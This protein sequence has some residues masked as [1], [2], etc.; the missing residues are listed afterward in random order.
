[1]CAE[2]WTHAD[3][4]IGHFNIGKGHRANLNLASDSRHFVVIEAKMSSR[5]SPGVRNAPFFNQAARNIACIAEVLKRADRQASGFDALGFHVVA[6]AS[7][8]QEGRF[9]KYLVKGHVREIVAKRVAQYG[10]KKDTWFSE[11]FLPVLERLEINEISWEGLIEY[12]ESRNSDVGPL[13]EFYRRCLK[14]NGVK[15]G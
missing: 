4:V 10:G 13:R 5:L 9:A 1:M 12:L 11:W 2:T 8:I 6:P 15:G 14:W 7:R 3:S